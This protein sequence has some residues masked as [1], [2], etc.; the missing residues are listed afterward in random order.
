MTSKIRCRYC[1]RIVHF[2]EPHKDCQEFM[3]RLCKNCGHRAINHLWWNAEQGNHCRRFEEIEHPWE[4]IDDLAEGATAQCG[5]EKEVGGGDAAGQEQP[6][7]DGGYGMEAGGRI[8][9]ETKGAGR[10]EKVKLFPLLKKTWATLVVCGAIVVASVATFFVLLF[11]VVQ[12]TWNNW[13][14]AFRR[15]QK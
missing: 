2:G 10:R 8:R 13:I 14:S 7:E 1:K 12:I 9:L 6:Q 11:G 5:D 4:K 3:N 15:Q